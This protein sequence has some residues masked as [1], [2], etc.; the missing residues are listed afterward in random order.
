MTITSLGRVV[1]VTPGTPVPLSGT[2]KQC[3]E[4]R[5]YLPLRVPARARPPAIF[6]TQQDLTLSGP[7]AP[8]VNVRT[9]KV[10]VAGANAVI[11]PAL[12]FQ[13]SKYPAAERLP[14]TG[15]TGAEIDNTQAIAFG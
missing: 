8:A 11:Q 7:P 4:K 10:R 6:K 3:R 15:M 12:G 1:S 5:L 9:S 13:S 2:S 14:V